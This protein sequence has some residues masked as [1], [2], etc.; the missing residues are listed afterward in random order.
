[1]SAAIDPVFGE[2][3]CAALRAQ[4]ARLGVALGEEPRLAN[5]SIEEKRDPFSQE[6]SLQVIWRDGARDGCMTFFVDGRVFAEYQ[7]LLPHP[8]QPGHYIEAVQVWGR[9][10]QLRGEPVIAEF[11]T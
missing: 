4:A 3:V 1:M 8:A 11:A 9:P 10:G 2:A 7:I 6:L 5:A